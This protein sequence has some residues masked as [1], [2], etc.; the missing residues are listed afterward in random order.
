MQSSHQDVSKRSAINPNHNAQRQQNGSA[1]HADAGPRPAASAESAAGRI[2]PEGGGAR[3]FKESGEPAC[4]VQPIKAHHLQSAKLHTETRGHKQRVRCMHGPA[5]AS[6]PS[7]C[8]CVC[9][10]VCVCLCVCVCVC[11][12]VRVCVC[13]CVCVCMYVRVRACVVELAVLCVFCWC[14]VCVGSYWCVLVCVF[15]CVCV[16]FLAPSFVH[17]FGH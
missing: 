16:V 17:P 4:G 3:S 13:V 6:R 15:L 10:C 9:V 8:A 5:Q 14:C 11:V 12:C 1:Q 7:Q 2:S